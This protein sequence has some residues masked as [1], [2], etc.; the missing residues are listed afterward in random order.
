M[1]GAV[2]GFDPGSDPDLY[3]RSDLG[4]MG[5]EV[6]VKV[7][8]EML[9]LA[10]GAAGGFEYLESLAYQDQ[11]S[12]EVQKSRKQGRRRWQRWQH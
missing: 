12:R 1:W 10:V 3:W 6:E 8:V 2:D 11:S 9:V 4:R 7:E 5:E